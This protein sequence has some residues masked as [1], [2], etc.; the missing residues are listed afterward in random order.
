MTENSC[1][2]ASLDKPLPNM[3]QKQTELPGW[4]TLAS[5]PTTPPYRITHNS[6]A[7]YLLSHWNPDRCWFHLL[8]SHRSYD[9]VCHS[10]NSFSWSVNTYA[11]NCGSKL[12]PQPC[13]AP[14]TRHVEASLLLIDYSVLLSSCVLNLPTCYRLNNASVLAWRWYTSSC[15]RSLR[16]SSSTFPWSSSAVETKIEAFHLVSTPSTHGM[17]LETARVC[18]ILLIHANISSPLCTPLYSMSL[19][20]WRKGQDMWRWH[21][22][23]WFG[24]LFQMVIQW[25]SAL[26]RSWIHCRFLGLGCSW[27]RTGFRFWLA[28]MCALYLW[29]IWSLTATLCS[30]MPTMLPNLSLLQDVT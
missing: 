23:G 2:Y 26:I 28:N 9:L 6:Q 29:S 20:S 15:P 25:L 19:H 30:W 16:S 22:P 8:F 27:A 7:F 13:P 24:S 14:L 11:D 5:R 4:F 17:I 18:L 21:S 3:Q 12:H 1:T 10:R